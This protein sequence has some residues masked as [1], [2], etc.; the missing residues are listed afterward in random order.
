[1]L[2]EL[3]ELFD[4]RRDERGC[5]ED[6]AQRGGIRGWLSRTF[7]GG[8]DDDDARAADERGCCSGEVV[9]DDGRVA[10]RHGCC[11]GND[12]VSDGTPSHQTSRRQRDRDQRDRGF[13]FGDNSA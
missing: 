7:G 10:R 4:G 9:D 2:D 8:G 1:M 3:L 12:G 5:G 6:P 11:A 13:D